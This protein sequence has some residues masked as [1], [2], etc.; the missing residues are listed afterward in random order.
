MC[1]DGELVPAKKPD[2]DNILKAVFDALQ[3]CAYE[4]D[5]QIVVIH[6]EKMYS[7]S[8]FVEVVIDE[9]KRT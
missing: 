1:I 9:Y 2:V 4:D 6:S 5:C 8:P 7:E 3:G